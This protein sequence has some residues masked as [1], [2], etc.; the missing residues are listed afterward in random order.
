MSGLRAALS[1]ELLKA[2]RSRVPWAIAAGFTLMPLVSGLFMV[3][4]QDPDRARQLGLLGAKAQLVAG[5]AD[6]PTMLSMLSQA[7]AIG[8]AVLFAFLT[9]WVYGREFADRTVRVVLANP[10]PRWSIVSAKALVVLAWGVAMSAWAIVLGLLVGYLIGLPGWSAEQALEAIGGIAL[11]VLLTLLLQTTT[12][13]V[14]SAGRGYLPPLAWAVL[15]VA[16]AQIMAVLGWG[17]VFPW[18]VPALL[19]GGGGGGTAEVGPEGYLLVT[20]TVLVGI[21]ATLVWW[22]RSDQTV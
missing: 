6:W 8:G 11:A 13:F 16:L 7:V 3:I 22:E 1:C 18:A 10:T 17:A 4:L 20:L 5:S 15:T 12:A 14:A 9:A 21:V 2:R 19:S